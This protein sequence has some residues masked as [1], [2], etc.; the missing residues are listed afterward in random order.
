MIKGM[1]DNLTQ[2]EL[3]TLH[4]VL[5]TA[6]RD[7]TR[8]KIRSYENPQQVAELRELRQELTQLGNTVFDQWWQNRDAWST[9]SQHLE[10]AADVTVWINQTTRDKW[11]GVNCTLVSDDSDKGYHQEVVPRSHQLRRVF[12]YWDDLDSDHDSV[13]HRAWELLNIGNDP[14]FAPDDETYKLA[15]EYRAREGSW[16]LSVGD[17]LEVN[18]KFWACDRDGWREVPRHELDLTG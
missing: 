2:D 9:P 14:E 18:G 3:T 5:R 8:A 11:L 12:R 13:L 4:E 1:Y 10:H 17:V 7:A 16:S 6:S 15:C